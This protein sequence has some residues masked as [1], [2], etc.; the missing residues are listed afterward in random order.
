MNWFEVDK[1]GLAKLLARKGENSGIVGQA[2]LLFELFQN[3][4]DTDASN[5][6]MTLKPIPGRSQCVLR[7]EDNS[8]AGFQNLAHSWTLFAESEKK[9]DPEKRG[10]FNLGEKLFLALCES[11]EISSTTGTVRFD[12]NGRHLG[13]KKRPQGTVVEALV[14]MTRKEFEEVSQAV[15]LLIPP[16]H[17]KTTYNGKS[18]S[19]IGAPI[20]S[21]QATLPTE[22]ADD[23]GVLRKRRRLTEVTLYPVRDGHTPFLYE[24]GIPVVELTGGEPWNI[25]IGQK[26]PLN[27]DRDNVTPAYLRELRTLVFNEAHALVQGTEEVSEAWVSEAISSE[28]ASVEALL[29]AKNTR[30]GEDAVT[31]DPKDLEANHRAVSAGFTVIPGGSLTKGAWSNLKK[32]GLV[33]PAGKV[34]PTQL[35]SV[36]AESLSDAQLTDGMKKLRLFTEGLARQLLGCSVTVEFFRSK[37]ATVS[38]QYGSRRISF[39]VSVLG[40]RW[41]RTGPNSAQL[42]LILHEFGHHWESNHLSEKYYRA[43]T[44]LGAELAFALS[45]DKFDLKSFIW[46]S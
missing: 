17:C 36:G 42:D 35:E 9:G 7:I 19:S 34:F 23:N 27:V 29:H 37:E 21:F 24:M 13:R 15:D 12:K 43:L 28:D 30:F 10:R 40:E 4:W 44:K 3:A 5:A 33:S 8:T 22:A 2:W 1:E 11:A 31:R 20:K 16:S 45:N 46:E 25:S 26:V 6:D 14:S 38:A 41:F 32:H 18:L 39:N